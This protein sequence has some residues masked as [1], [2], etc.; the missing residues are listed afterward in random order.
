MC[1]NNLCVRA[2]SLETRGKLQLQPRRPS[3]QAIEPFHVH[4]NLINL[5]KLPCTSSTRAFGSGGHGIRSARKS[6][7]S[8]T[9]ICHHSDPVVYR[10][11]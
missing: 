3:S 11:I 8:R 1:P 10:V 5:M 6:Y 2:L 7:H 9:G 4:T